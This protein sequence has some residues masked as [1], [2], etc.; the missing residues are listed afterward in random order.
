MRKVLLVLVF[1]VACSAT[2]EAET[3]LCTITATGNSTSVACQHGA[4]AG[5]VQE[6]D[7]CV[8]AEVCSAFF[9]YG[10]IPPCSEGCYFGTPGDP[11]WECLKDGK[12][13]GY[14]GACQI[15]QT[16][17]GFCDPCH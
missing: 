9:P 14:V 4:A 5:T 11:K 3:P 7:S 8:G 10:T 12:D 6:E 16:Y 13:A 17:H 1:V 2:S 15:A